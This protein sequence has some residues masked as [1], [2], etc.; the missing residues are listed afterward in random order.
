M[1]LS[2]EAEPIVQAEE[3]IENGRP[4]RKK[5]YPKEDEP[6][7]TAAGLAR[8]EDRSLGE[9]FSELGG[10][11]G[12]CIIKVERKYPQDW[13]GHHIGG[14]LAQF[15]EP[16]TEEELKA[17]YG[18]GKFYIRTWTRSASG[19]VKWGGGRTVTIAGDPKISGELQQEREKE[20]VTLL[21]DDGPVTLQQKALDHMQS[22]A[23]SAQK[24]T[25]QLEDEAREEAKSKN[26]IDPTLLNL[27]MDPPAMKAMEARLAELT[28]SLE[29]K[30]AQ[31][32]ELITKKPESTFS[33]KLATELIGGENSRIEA[34]RE[35]FAS[36]RRQ[37]QQSAQDDLKRER[38]HLTNELQTRERAHER[39]IS[40]LRESQSMQVKSIEQAYEARLDGMKGRISDLER[41][42][43]ETKTEVVELR[44]KKDKGP[45]D[46]MEEVVR[47]KTTLEGLGLGGQP[48]VEEKSWPE[49]LMETVMQSPLAA[50]VASRIE[51]APAA[52]PQ[53]M[54]RRTV[55]RAA[56]QQP[57][58]SGPPV[59]TRKRGQQPPVQPVPSQG[60][61]LN[62]A[63]VTVAINFIESAVK[64][65]TDPTAF[66]QSVRTMVPAQILDLL[67]TYGADRFLDQ[68]A[69]QVIDGGSVL[70]TMSGRQ[71]M[72][73]VTRVLITGSV[74]P[75][76][77]EEPAAEPPAEP[78]EPT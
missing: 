29:K 61:Q 17:R 71:F 76:P 72:R 27:A 64:N 43:T 45:I 22:L 36:E 35:N 21:R 11:S 30:D 1:S 19:G 41:Q 38:E 25:W 5:R 24:R 4:E 46:A 66:A 28:R 65:G 8:L 42:L 54:P 56:P 50:S 53:P 20:P 40:T 48:E 3:P 75:V 55:R 74:S 77:P 67:R 63:E 15:D 51:N 62:A 34:L 49:R 59:P 2:D 23:T 69:G 73:K 78:A 47:I 68:I 32:L 44:A 52:A 6:S 58:V 39:E 70:R 26:A 57:G 12:T 9:W 13:Q 60:I 31:I 10:A 7:Q 33:E 14:H 16:F 18:G 37:L